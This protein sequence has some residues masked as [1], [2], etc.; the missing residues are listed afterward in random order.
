MTAQTTPKA[1]GDAAYETWVGHTIACAACRT[2]APC[3]T[4]IRLGRAWRQA[5]R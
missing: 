1:A 4:A 5:R 3:V 2:G